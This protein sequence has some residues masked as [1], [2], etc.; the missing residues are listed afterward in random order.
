VNARFTCRAR[1][2]TWARVDLTYPSTSI[3]RRPTDSE[4]CWRGLS[5]HKSVVTEHT[6]HGV[7]RLTGS[8]PRRALCTNLPGRRPNHSGSAAQQQFPVIPRPCR[9]TRKPHGHGYG[10]CAHRVA[11]SAWSPARWDSRDST[12]AAVVHGH[13]AVSER[14]RR[15]QLEL[16]RV[17]QSALVQ[18][19]AVAG[20]PRMDEQLVLVDQVQP[21]ELGR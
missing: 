3:Q 9:R 5:V 15:E 12:G 21:V 11:P 2:W 16:T 7:S 6:R 17:G 1:C 14:P 18:R 8:E 4:S 10:P 13:R 20:D 19:R